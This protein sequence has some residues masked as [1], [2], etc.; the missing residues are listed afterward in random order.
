[1]HGGRCN[2][3]F[4]DNAAGVDCSDHEVNIK[5]ALNALVAAG[6]MTE[7]Q[8]RELLR[9]M[10]DTVGELVLRHNYRQ[11]QAL[12]LAERQALARS[13][14]YER[15]IRHMES[16]GWLQ[17][18]LEFIPTD[19][20]LI[21]RKAGGSGLTRPELAVLISYTKAQLKAA[22]AVPAIADDPLLAQ[23]LFSA[24]PAV[25]RESYRPA[26]ERHRLRTQIIGTKIAN[27][28][29]D[30]MG[31][32]FVERIGQ[33]TGAN[34]VEVARAFVTAREVFDMHTWW[35]RIEALDDRVD[36]ALQ[37]DMM[38]VV[39][40]LVRRAT[41]WFIRNRRVHLQPLREVERFRASIAEL[42]AQY[43]DILAG[44]APPGAAA[45]AGAGGSRDL[46]GDRAL[47]L[48]G[49]QHH[50]R[51]HRIERAGAQDGRGLHGPGAGAGA[52]CLR[53]ADRRAE[54]GESLAGAG[55]RNLPRRSRMAAAQAGGRRARPFM[56]AG[57]CA[58]LHSALAANA[59]TVGGALAGIID[60]AAWHRCEGVRGIRGGDSGIVGFGAEYVSR[61]SVI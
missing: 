48:S 43:P 23:A 54:G 46:R 57:G 22:L 7:K 37:L 38:A 33:S 14:E 20:A 41:R 10:T 50:R 8:R 17:R 1:L 11:T 45:G 30:L 19:E 47:P 24:F 2:T 59:A 52:R 49:A 32:T 13:G 12:S 35:E 44:R 15:L 3:D 36:A 58:G 60:G 56:S 61:G 5:I 42:Y 29:V 51:R 21:E 9:A 39:M 28:M 34:A 53:Q 25:L 6:D 26:L 27:D 55:A 40:R 18:G 31:I 4:I 16:S